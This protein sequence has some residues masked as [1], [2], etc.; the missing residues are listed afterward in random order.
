[1][2]AAVQ[3][4]A[5]AIA[6]L[7]FGCAALGTAEDDFAPRF[8]HDPDEPR[9]VSRTDE[10]ISVRFTAA[11]NAVEEA[12]LLTF[13]G[14]I[15]FTRQL[16]SRRS[17]TWRVL[18][19][20]IHD[21]Y[22]IEVK[23]SNG[24]RE[25]HGPHEVPEEMFSEVS[26]VGESIGYQIFP[27]RFRNSNDEATLD[28]RAQAALDTDAYNYT[29]EE[30]WPYPDGALFTE[31]WG[32]DVAEHHCCHQYF[33]GDFDGIASKLDYLESLGVTMIYMNPVVESGSAHGY[34]AHDFLSVAPNFGTE[35]ELSALIDQAHDRDM[36]VMWDFV[37][38]HVGVGHY[39]F[40]DALEHGWDSEYADWFRFHVDPSDAVPGTGDNE[41][42]DGWWGFG[43]LPELDTE[44]EPVLEHLMEVTEYWSKF[45]FDGIRVDVPNEIRNREEFFTKF[46]ETAKA[47]D[48]DQYLVGEVWQQDASWLQ[49]DEFDS[50]MNYAIGQP[51]IEQFVTGDKNAA[52][53]AYDM[54]SLYSEY[55]EASVAMQFN[56]ITSHDTA[57]LATSMGAD[58]RGGDASD[59]HRERHKLA[60]ALLYAIPGMPV[61]WQGDERGVLGDGQGPQEENRY[62]IQWDEIHEPTFEHYEKLGSVRNEIDAF[63][64]PLI[65]DIR[66]DGDVLHFRRGEPGEGALLIAANAGDKAGSIDLPDGRWTDVISGES[67]EHEADIDI[68]SFRYLQ[69]G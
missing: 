45:G 48:E 30:H 37:P 15:P 54:A 34:D 27:E 33:G 44:Y 35:E 38:N 7:L 58:G 19:P 6:A 55:P 20:D 60:A 40:V 56:L 62:P 43:S 31:G 51:V 32:G 63:S 18:R 16:A 22:A 42:Y 53:A 2:R 52:A 57:R 68:R 17:T 9:Y 10:G 59:V 23:Y 67:F 64:S 12:H 4:I 11:E 21:R 46:R 65:Y 28:E 13:D 3:V 8:R 29:A 49:G 36:R 41:H 69:R 66:G 24:E 14:Q 50:L 5:L 47:V 25:V 39:A 26:W 1:M 61:T